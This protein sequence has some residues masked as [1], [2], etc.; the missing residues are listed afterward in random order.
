MVP[1]SLSV[2]GQLIE[3]EKLVYESRV[4]SNEDLRRFHISEIINRFC[5]SIPSV[6]FQVI[7]FLQ[8]M[9]ALL[10]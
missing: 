1:S 3:C 6:L 4:L 10:T 7:F 5:V 8:H 2:E 9:Q